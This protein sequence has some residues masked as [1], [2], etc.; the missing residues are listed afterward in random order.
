MISQNA[1]KIMAQIQIGEISGNQCDQPMVI[2]IMVLREINV[3]NHEL[4]HVKLVGAFKH[5]DSF[6]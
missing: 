1:W 3:T 6:P 5:L 4:N 2:Q